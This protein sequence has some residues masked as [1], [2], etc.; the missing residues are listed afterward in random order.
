MI[1]FQSNAKA[2]ICT[3]PKCTFK[4]QAAKPVFCL[5]H[6]FQQVLTPISA[7]KFKTAPMKMLVLT[8]VSSLLGL[9]VFAA[10]IFCC[11]SSDEGTFFLFFTFTLCL[12]LSLSIINLLIL[13]CFCFAKAMQ[14]VL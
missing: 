10:I 2:T 5:P 11:V 1:Y 4:T 3:E 13:F 12:F 9:L 6:R 7:L 14:K 8:F